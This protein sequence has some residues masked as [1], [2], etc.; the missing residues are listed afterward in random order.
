[1][2]FDFSVL[3]NEW[4]ALLQGLGLTIF[5][6]IVGSALGILLGFIVALAQLFLG[7][8]VRAVLQAYIGLI[9]GT[10]F[11][12]QLFVLYYGGPFYGLDLSPMTAGI[13]GLL[14]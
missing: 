5:I 10:P 1:M 12:I 14:L 7:A 11:L 6:W 13:L 9:R 2:T 3:T 8:A 4:R